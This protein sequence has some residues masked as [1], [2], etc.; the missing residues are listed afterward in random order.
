MLAC[1]P[2]TARFIAGKVAAHY[3]GVPSNSEIV[4]VMSREY[5]R[6]NGDLRRMIGVMIKSPH[7]MAVN[8][9]PKVMTPIE[10]GVS[11]Q[12]VSTSFNPWTVIGLADRS[13]RNLFDRASPDGF[14][15]TN[16]EYS[17]SN[18]QLQKWSYCKELEGAFGNTLPHDW[19]VAE[20]MKDPVHRD[21]VIDHTYAAR[22]GSAPSAATREALHA[23]LSQEI[24]DPNQRRI[25]FAS[26]LH[27]MPEFQSR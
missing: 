2:E 19:F 27:M 6:T 20:K 10:F 3:V 21:A 22:R 16:E 8:L 26:F 1:R 23:I 4:D 11:M 13:G 15:E 24:A 7:F 5:L 12:R 9:M 14:P 17:D 18:Y 25:L